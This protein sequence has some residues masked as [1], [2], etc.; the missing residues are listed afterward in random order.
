[1]RTTYYHPRKKPTLCHL[2]AIANIFTK[3]LIALLGW[4]C[5]AIY[6]Q[7]KYRNIIHL[8]LLRYYTRWNNNHI[9]FCHLADLCQITPMC[10][11][12][13]LNAGLTDQIAVWFTVDPNHHLY[14]L[15][16]LTPQ[17]L[18][19]LCKVWITVCSDICIIFIRP[20]V[21]ATNFFNL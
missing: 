17:L 10:A 7:R 20:A 19:F 3:I 4:F 21:N 9:S 8:Y 11:Y 13:H 15:C 1:M 5:N 6:V 18:N 14:R 12:L 2:L 16:D